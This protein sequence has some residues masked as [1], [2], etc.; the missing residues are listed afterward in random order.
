MAFTHTIQRKV[1]AAGGAIQASNDYTGESQTSI[2]E[3]VPIQSDYEVAFTLDVSAI[4]AIFIMSDQDL[5]LETND[6]GSP[7]DTISLLANV[8][9]VWHTGS[10]FVNKLTTNITALFLTNASAAAARFQLEVV[11][12][13]TP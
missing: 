1:I 4:K 11:F 8:P 3:S 12:D 6:G 9:Y 5:T 7:V 13:P 2:D 10:Y